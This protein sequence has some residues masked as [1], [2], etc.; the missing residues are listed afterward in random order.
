METEGLSFREAVEKL[1][2][3]QGVPSPLRGAPAPEREKSAAGHTLYDVNE[4]ATQWF[5]LQLESPEGLAAQAYLNGRDLD[6]GVW[7]QFRMGFAPDQR[8]GLLSHLA[9]RGV[10][11]EEILALGLAVTPEDGRN[12]YD[13]FRGRV[14]FPILDTRGRPIAFGGRTLLPDGK[15]KYLNSPETPLFKKGAV[16]FNHQAARA[17]AAKGEPVLVAEGYVDVIALVRAGFA[18][19][20][21]PLGTALTEEQLGLL[22]RMADEPVLCFDG[23][24]AG[25]AAAQRAMDRALP[26]IVPG[27]S[28]R[29]AFLPAGQDPDD[30]LRAQGRDA[31]AWVIDSAQPLVEALWQREVAVLDPSTPERVAGLRARLRALAAQIPDTDLRYDY[32]RSF[33][34]RLNGL[35][36]ER[37]GPVGSKAR[38]GAGAGFGQGMPQ[39]RQ[40]WRPNGQ[41]GGSELTAHARLSRPGRAQWTARESPD[42]RASQLAQSVLYGGK[43]SARLREEALVLSIINNPELLERHLDEVARLPLADPLLDKIRQALLHAAGW[44]NPLDFRGLRDHLSRCGFASDVDRL[45]RRPPMKG[46]PFVR[47]QED[48]GAVEWA[49]LHAVQ[50]HLK[51]TQLEAEH[52]LAA[53]AL[54]TDESVEALKRLQEIDRQ[55][56]Q[57]SSPEASAEDD[58]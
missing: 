8:N 35:I 41:G 7:A 34:D 43:G 46:L 9:S 31:M 13:R 29:F 6:R 28:L 39:A 15:P 2:A 53:D 51:L 24:K 30:L 50:R 33:Q 4:M 1:A 56:K 54:L 45:E 5:Q 47:P 3:E 10:S 21:A 52:R 14:I 57:A 11:V 42:M 32:N 40:P 27:K 20:V 36:D 25:L 58:F 19:A 23:D 12:P 18:G 49:W 22:W 55:I 38:S 16:L 17:A 37:R 44:G 26:E 48:F